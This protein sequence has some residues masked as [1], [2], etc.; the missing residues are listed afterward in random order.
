MLDDSGPGKASREA[1]KGAASLAPWVYRQFDPGRLARAAGAAFAEMSP[2]VT[3][4]PFHRHACPHI[5]LSC[6][7]K[8]TLSAL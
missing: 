4:S 8:G 6:I 7:C 1:L 3:P 2:L 5:K